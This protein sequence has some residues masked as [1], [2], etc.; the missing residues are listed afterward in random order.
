[1]WSVAPLITLLGEIYMYYYVYLI[2][3]IYCT[4]GFIDEGNIL[5]NWKICQIKVQLNFSY[6]CYLTATQGTTTVSLWR[7]VVSSHSA[8]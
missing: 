8:F 6:Y 4:V 2:K 3:S 7:D 1:M 5:A